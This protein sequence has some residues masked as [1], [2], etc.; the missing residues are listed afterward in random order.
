MIG[1]VNQNY[2]FQKTH[3]GLFYSTGDIVS[4][5]K[6]KNLY[7]TARKENYIKHKGYRVNLDSI[8]RIIKNKLKKECKLIIKDNRIII[9]FLK[10]TKKFVHKKFNIFANNY[11]EHYEKPDQIVYLNKFI[12]N[13]SGK[14]DRKSLSKNLN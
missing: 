10:K 2:K 14:I 12:Y 11:L 1:Y 3:Q 6:N 7:F 8:E 4:T 9:I 5:D 13:S